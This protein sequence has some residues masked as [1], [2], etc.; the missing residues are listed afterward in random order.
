MI[1]LA[2]CQVK[3]Q[4]KQHVKFVPKYIKTS[5]KEITYDT[6]YGDFVYKIDFRGTIK[7]SG[8]IVTETTITHEQLKPDSATQIYLNNKWKSDS[9][10]GVRGYYNIGYS[11]AGFSSIPDRAHAYINING[12]YYWIAQEYTFTPK[13]TTK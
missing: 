5:Y 11:Q 6:L 10:K 4:H 8:Y 1:T 7:G 3:A 13:T 9:A 2:A 12:K